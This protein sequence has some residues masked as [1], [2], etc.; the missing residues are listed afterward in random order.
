MVTKSTA[1]VFDGIERKN[2]KAYHK[3]HIN[4]TMTVAFT[5]H[6]FKDRIDNGGDGIKF[7]FFRAQSYKIAK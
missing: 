7:G 6:A 2:L 1:R 5:A 3:S 4:K